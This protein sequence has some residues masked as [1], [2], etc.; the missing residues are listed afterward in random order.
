MPINNLTDQHFSPADMHTIRTLLDSLHNAISPKTRNLSPAE[1]QEYGS[2]NEQNKLVV[3]KVRDYR[4]QQP[5]LSSPQIDWNEFEADFADRNFLEELLSRIRNLLDMTSDCKILHDHDVYK[6]ALNDYQYTR[7]MA[8]TEAPGYD[9]K[10]DDIRRL[11]PST[12]L[13]RKKDQT[14]G[15]EAGGG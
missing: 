3:H 7:Y 1:R 9:V 2:I 8:G 12:G 14:P 15:T 6:T 11:F 4:Q 13:R 10:M 5:A